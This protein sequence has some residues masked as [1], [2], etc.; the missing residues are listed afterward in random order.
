MSPHDRAVPVRS[1]RLLAALVA[2]LILA[3]C[4]SRDAGDAAAVR[5]PCALLRA[6]EVGTIMGGGPLTGVPSTKEDVQDCTWMVGGG[7]AVIAE[8]R[9][10]VAR[11]E[12]ARRATEIVQR[13]EAQDLPGIGDEAFY[14][15]GEAGPLAIATV[16]AR[17]GSVAARVQV[18]S[19]EGDPV[20]LRN[21]AVELTRLLVPRL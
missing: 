19:P 6:E 7:V 21:Q 8:V 13:D 1:T 15:G 17:K 12:S 20:T 16:G 9:P 4:A 2:P 10:D 18:M 11:L 5:S 3:G 14:V